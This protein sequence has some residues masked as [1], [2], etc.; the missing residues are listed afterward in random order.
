[1]YKFEAM[2]HS[3]EEMKE[4]VSRRFTEDDAIEANIGFGFRLQ[5]YEQLNAL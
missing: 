2:S 5:Q 1:M 4:L 3:I